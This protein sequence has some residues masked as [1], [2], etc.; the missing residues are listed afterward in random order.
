MSDKLR[1]RHELEQAFNSIAKRFEFK[2][3]HLE[4]MSD[5]RQAD[6]LTFIKEHFH[7]DEP[8]IKCIGYTADE[9]YDQ[10]ATMIH[11]DNL[12]LLLVSD[13]TNE[14]IACRTIGLGHRDEPY[15]L[16]EL[17]N[18]KLVTLS[19][20]FTHKNEEMDIYKRFNTDTSIDFLVLG[21]HKD[22]RKQ[23]IA[24]KIFQAALLFS[25]ELGLKPAFIHGDATGVY[26]QRIFE[27]SGFETLHTFKY[28]EYK[29]DD[30]IVFKDTGIHKSTKVYVKQL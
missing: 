3:A 9:E 23:G 18:E 26:S 4:L 17:E 28:D 10:L 21:T 8:L 22:H 2:D 6:L 19:K 7:P 27:K 11:K 16:S 5:G 25:K 30:E 20:F 24:S 29:V 15:D 13:K 12:S 14:I 1:P